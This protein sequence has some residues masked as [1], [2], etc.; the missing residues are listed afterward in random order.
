MLWSPKA[1]SLRL[2]ATSRRRCQ[3][4]RMTSA[5][6]STLVARTTISSCSLT[7]SRPTSRP[8]RYCP[9]LSPGR[10]IRPASPP[11]IST[12]SSTWLT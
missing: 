10:A 9:K 6:T 3:F 1:A 7:L 5:P 12:C 8:S 11:T 4:R 2:Y